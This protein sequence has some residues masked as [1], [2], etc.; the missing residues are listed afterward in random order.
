VA[1]R[2]SRSF[3]TWPEAIRYPARV[4][5]GLK[6]GTQFASLNT[7]QP[8]FTNLKARQAVNYAIDRARIIQHGPDVEK[9]RR[10]A[11]ES[12]TMNM[13]VTVWSRN[14]RH[15]KAAG[16]H[17]VGLLDDLGYRARLHAVSRDQFF[18]DIYNP[19]L[20][21]QV[22]IGA[23]W[24]A[25]YPAPSTFFG[26]LL[27]CRSA[28]QPGTQNLARFCEPHVD[29]LAS[30]A[31]AAQLTDPAA[32]RRLWAQADRIVTDQAPYVPVLNSG[33]AGFVSSRLGSYQESPVYGLLVD[34]M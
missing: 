9:A 4:Y 5:P 13:P 1:R 32:A 30:Q 29:A 24:G 18:A 20:K 28:D 33:T 25:D 10:L 3:P 31:Q 22:S 16:S 26:P 21:I 27:S 23:G 11:R 6:N 8:P 14:D 17:L 7:R 34:Q 2:G 12:G 15:G 19:R